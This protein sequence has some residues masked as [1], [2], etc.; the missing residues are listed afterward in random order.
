MFAHASTMTDAPWAKHLML[1]CSKPQTPK[2]L[3]RSSGREILS[4]KP[5][6][7]GLHRPGTRDKVPSC[8]QAV[9]SF[10][11]TAAAAPA[12]TSASTTATTN[13]TSTNSTDITR[14]TCYFANYY[15][16]TATLT[17]AAIADPATTSA[18]AATAA[19]TASTASTAAVATMAFSDYHYRC[20]SHVHDR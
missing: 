11:P 9:A 12:T 17:A 10:P 18:T 14:Y 7:H 1:F 16:S 5:R 15:A 13:T 19:S 8:V 3:I 20:R 6:S 4:P 2:W